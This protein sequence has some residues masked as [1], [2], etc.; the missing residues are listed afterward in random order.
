M[1]ITSPLRVILVKSE[2]HVWHL[3]SSGDGNY[4]KAFTKSWDGTDVAGTA[5]NVEHEEGAYGRLASQG[6]PSAEVAKLIRTCDNPLCRPFVLTRKAVGDTLMALLEHAP[7]REFRALLE[8][9]GDNLRR[10]NA[11]TCANP[12]YA[13]ADEP[14]GPLVEGAWRHTCWT[15]Q[16]MQRHALKVLDAEADQLTLDLSRQL[17]RVFNTTTG[18]LCSAFDPAHFVQG[19]CQINHFFLIQDGRSSQVTA[20]IDME[21]ASAGDTLY[22]LALLAA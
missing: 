11:I 16:P 22:D 20:S 15:V 8:A 1:A 9:T 4:L 19:N 6:L 12:A 3:Q 5:Y 21:A 18:E 10:M 14:S 13:T 7:G 17:R 2:S